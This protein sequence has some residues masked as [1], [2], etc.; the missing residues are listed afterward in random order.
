MISFFRAR[1]IIEIKHLFKLFVGELF[2]FTVDVIMVSNLHT[3][4]TGF[5][6]IQ[7]FDSYCWKN[8]SWMILIRARN[9]VLKSLKPQHEWEY[10]EIVTKPCRIHVWYTHQLV[11][12]CVKIT[13]SVESLEVIANVYSYLTLSHALER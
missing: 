7:A 1:G 12:K 4:E 8:K 2:S 11:W 13:V 6:L 3:K 10:V 5:H 9:V